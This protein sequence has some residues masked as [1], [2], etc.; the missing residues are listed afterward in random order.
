[1]KK[2][3]VL[4]VIASLFFVNLAWGQSSILKRLYS[5][6]TITISAVDGSKTITNSKDVF[7]LW[8][9]PYFEDWNLNKPDQATSEIKIQVYEMTQ[10]ANLKQM[11]SS[12][13]DCLDKLCL[14]QHQI[15]EFCAKDQK[16]L[17]Q[18][19]RP[20]FFLFKVDGEYF[21]ADVYVYLDGLFVIVHSF[22]NSNTWGGKFHHRLVVPQP[23]V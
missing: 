17:R 7:K 16:Y 4:F 22:E 6:D 18:N 21:V 5:D 20:T 10:N 11:F 19:C 3:T 13:N 8:I 2:L 15:A 1:M 9:D 23:K 14:T 12:L